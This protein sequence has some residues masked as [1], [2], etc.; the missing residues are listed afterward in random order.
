MPNIIE[1]IRR[2]AVFDPET[3][4]VMSDAYERALASFDFPPPKTVREVIAAR[5]IVMARKGQ[6]D[7]HLLCDGAIEAI[8]VR[9]RRD[10]P[11]SPSHR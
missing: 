11:S 5:I 2:P 4:A 6:R 10:G 7:P 3:I 8:P 1:Y 9:S